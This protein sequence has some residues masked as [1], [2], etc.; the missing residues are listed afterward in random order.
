MTSSVENQPR[1]VSQTQQYEQC[2]WRWYLQ[3][4]ARV[5]PRPAAWSVHGTAFHSAAEAWERS[6]RTLAVDEVT[7]LFHDE[8]T[9]NV[10]AALAEE[11]DTDRWMSAGRY[12]GGED[13]ERRYHLGMEQ[14]AAYVEWSKANRPALWTEPYKQE[15]ALE[16][17]F[18]VELGGVPVRGF[19][20]QALD[21]GDGSVRVRDLKTGT[22]KSKFQLQTYSVAVRKLWGVAVTKADWYLARDG[23]LSRPLKVGEVSEDEIGQRF[24]DMDAAVKRGDF[25]ANPGFDCRFCDVSH[26]CVFFSTKT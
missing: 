8:Y 25:P 20:D 2:G 9:S 4:V 3:R 6:S 15:P 19:I 12:T 16:L 17:S 23:R 7:E 5:R 10:N 18:M 24:A 26:A 11:P 21:E 22:M 13:I 14:T 1:S